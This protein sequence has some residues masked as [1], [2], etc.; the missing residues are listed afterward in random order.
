MAGPAGSEL[1]AGLLAGTTHDNPFR[2]EREMVPA[3]QAF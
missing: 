3:T 1:L 2:V